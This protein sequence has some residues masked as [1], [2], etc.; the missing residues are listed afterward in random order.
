MHPLQTV[1][2]IL[3]VSSHRPPHSYLEAAAKR[4]ITG[5]PSY[6]IFR[7]VGTSRVQGRCWHRCAA[8]AG[9]SVYLWGDVPPVH[10]TNGT[11]CC[12]R[13]HAAIAFMRDLRIARFLARIV[14]GFASREALSPCW[15]C[16]FSSP[17]IVSNGEQPSSVPAG[18]LMILEPQRC[19]KTESE[20]M[21]SK[22][23]GNSSSFCS[24]ACS[25]LTIDSI[26]LTRRQSRCF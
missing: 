22:I 12:C 3:E 4:K 13:F 2:C 14:E 11:F 16:Y 24:E 18:L 6:H 8:T 19:L 10:G 15:S 1:G 23:A 25:S 5:F 26:T 20:L 7:T 17:G 21:E 9:R